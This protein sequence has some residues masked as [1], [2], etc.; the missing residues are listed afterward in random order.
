MGTSIGFAVAPLLADGS[1]DSIT[2]WDWSLSEPLHAVAPLAG[3][4]VN[5][6]AIGLGLAGDGAIVEIDSAASIASTHALGA[7]LQAGLAEANASV[8][9][10]AHGLVGG[11]TFHLFVGTDRGLFIVD[12]LPPGTKRPDH[13]ASFTRLNPI[14]FQPMLTNFAVCLGVKRQPSRSSGP[15]ARRSAPSNAQA[16]WFGTPS[17][18]HKLDL[19]DDFI[20]HSGLMTHRA[21]MENSRANP[22][23]STPF[24]PQVMSC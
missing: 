12:T 2:A 3:E 15:R 11:T 4:D 18:L 23:T 24:T 21:L 6:H 14:P 1:L 10:I 5:L 7:G 9:A 17:G 20:E 16:L 8:N 19:N 22:T 13:G